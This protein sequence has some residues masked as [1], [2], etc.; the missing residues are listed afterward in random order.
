MNLKLDFDLCFL[1]LFN[2]I[3]ADNTITVS[4]ID[5]D[6][7]VCELEASTDIEYEH[8]GSLSLHEL[9]VEGRCGRMAI[10]TTCQRYL[11][12]DHD[13]PE[14]SDSELHMLDEAFLWKTIVV[15]VARFKLQTILM[16]LP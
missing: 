4:L 16:G 12:S 15:W 9:S 7:L 5:R 3:M 11:E 14:Q 8:H 2:K 6:G 10:C 13:L 1:S